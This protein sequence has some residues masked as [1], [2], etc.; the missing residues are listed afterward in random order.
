MEAKEGGWTVGS[1]GTAQGRGAPPL[2][3]VLGALGWAGGGQQVTNGSQAGKP[4]ACCSV[5]E[6]RSDGC[7]RSSL[8]C[9]PVKPTWLHRSKAETPMGPS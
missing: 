4:W 3:A 8:A 1:T 6:P 7:P 5:Q 9:Q 2:G